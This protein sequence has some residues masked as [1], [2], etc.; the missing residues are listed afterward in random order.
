MFPYI[1]VSIS[2]AYS[3]IIGARL[4]LAASNAVSVVMTDVGARKTCALNDYL[5]RE[6]SFLSAIV[7]TAENL[8]TRNDKE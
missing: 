5:D 1:P 6:K 7:G 2:I 4:S 3:I 8:E